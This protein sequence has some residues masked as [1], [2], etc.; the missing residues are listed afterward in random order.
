M[1][2]PSHIH[3]FPVEIYRSRVYMTIGETMADAINRLPDE[4]A[5][6]KVLETHADGSALM[7]PDGLGGFSLNFQY[8]DVDLDIVAHELF[9]LTIDIL[10]RTSSNLDNDHDEQGAL[11]MG[12]LMGKVTKKL[13][14]WEVKL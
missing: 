6:A 9:H 2:R 5:K 11:L 7:L 4:F 14:A 13:R 3:E 1:K 12:W 10:H 8:D